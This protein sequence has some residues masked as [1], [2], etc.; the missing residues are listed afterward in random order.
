MS[1]A[2]KIPGAEQGGSK[3]D[4][5]EVMTSFDILPARIRKFVRESAFD[6][7]VCTIA[8]HMCRGRSE[9]DLLA[10][11]YSQEQVFLAECERSRADA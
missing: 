6:W 11:L 3:P 7:N 8:E 4:P 9:V 10:H 5:K 2:S 1:N